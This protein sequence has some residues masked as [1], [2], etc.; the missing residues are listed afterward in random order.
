MK[1]KQLVPLNYK[2]NNLIA[3]VTRQYRNYNTK[4]NNQLLNACIDTWVELFSSFEVNGM[5]KLIINITE[6]REWRK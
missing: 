1:L 2:N 6:N 3:I 5:Y 4:V